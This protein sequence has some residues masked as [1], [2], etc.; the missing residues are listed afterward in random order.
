MCRQ[1]CR[2]QKRE[3]GT[4]AAALVGH[5]N[6][7]SRQHKNKILT[8]I[9][10]SCQLEEP[11]RRV[12]A[13]LL[14]EDDEFREYRLWNRHSEQ[15]KD[16]RKTGQPKRAG[17]KD[18]DKG[19]SPYQH[20]SEN[21]ERTLI[22]RAERPRVEPR[23]RDE[24]QTRYNHDDRWNPVE[25]DLRKNRLPVCIYEED[26]HQRDQRCLRK[27]PVLGDERDERPHRIPGED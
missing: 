12:R 13:S 1:D 3:A 11:S 18:Q 16:Q 4:Y 26:A 20:D 23:Q 25:G 14:K 24:D 10:N 8:E 9:R 6:S 19:A 15:Q 27:R 2:N 5:S 21:E 17:A 7:K 22:N